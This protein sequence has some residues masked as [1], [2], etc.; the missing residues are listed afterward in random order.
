MR[1]AIG[2]MGVLIFTGTLI[3]IFRCF[4]AFNLVL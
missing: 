4:R 1:L 3:E 2:V